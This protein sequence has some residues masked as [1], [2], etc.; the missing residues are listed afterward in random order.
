MPPYIRLAAPYGLY[1]LAVK[2]AS[3]AQKGLILDELCTL[4]SWTRRHA[5]RE[6]ARALNGSMINLR[7]T[8]ARTYGQEVLEPLKFVWAALGGPAGKRLAPFMREAVE[9]LERHGELQLNN[10][11]RTKLLTVSAATID[12]ML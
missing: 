8:R 12:R 5:R 1:G 10:E 9:A 4:T 6:L 2:E 11:V 3:K 7:K